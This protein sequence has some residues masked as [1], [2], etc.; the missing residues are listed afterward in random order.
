MGSEAELVD[1]VA[2][3]L[4]PG[5]DYELDEQEEAAPISSR[6]PRRFEMSSRLNQS[7]QHLVAQMDAPAQAFYS[8]HIQGTPLFSFIRENLIAPYRTLTVHAILERTAYMR[9]PARLQMLLVNLRE[10]RGRAQVVLQRAQIPANMH[11]AMISEVLHR[12]ARYSGSLYNWQDNPD[13]QDEQRALL[14][15]EAA[16]PLILEILCQGFH[17]PDLREQDDSLQDLVQC[18]VTITRRMAHA[19]LLK[20]ARGEV[21]LK[22][23]KVNVLATTQPYRSARG[24]RCLPE[25]VAGLLANA[26]LRAIIFNILL[27]DLADDVQDPVKFEL[28]RQIPWAEGGAL[29][30]VSAGRC[31]ELRAEVPEGWEEYFDLAVRAWSSFVERLRA[32]VGEEAFAR[33]LAQLEADYRDVL[34]SMAYALRLNT[35]VDLLQDLCADAGMILAHNMNMMAFET[36][37]RMALD[38]VNPALGRALDEEPD[39][40]RAIR[41][42]NLLLQYNGQLGNS[43]AT[44]DAEIDE[45]CAA[46]EVVYIASRQEG[47]E[48]I[49][50][51]YQ[52]RRDAL[53]RQDMKTYAALGARIREV[54]ARTG[55]RAIYFEQWGR[56][57]RRILE[58]VAKQPRVG[59]FL[60]VTAMLEAHDKLLLTSWVYRGDI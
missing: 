40:Y 37:D 52:G 8:R 18:L 19:G 12:T 56:T 31:R 45:N 48:D 1:T 36:M 27:D 16:L 38:R 58:I 44:L 5:E 2:E 51:L 35:S 49:C 15:E 46:N 43:T 10:L 29:G 28:F 53:G 23:C 21:V 33:H 26:K 34:G 11:A 50:Q 41:E 47:G 55:A 42:V 6:D 7:V 17:E 22:W 14:R 24:E 25:Q 4:V 20:K 59:D 9:N 60:D 3:T 30:P 13:I 32:I 54:I 39:V 57:K